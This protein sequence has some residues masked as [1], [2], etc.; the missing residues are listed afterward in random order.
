MACLHSPLDLGYCSPQQEMVLSTCR[1]CH[2]V[3]HLQIT[4]THVC[5]ASW[6]CA[7]LL[8]IQ[9]AAETNVYSESDAVASILSPANSD[10]V[11][12]DLLSY[13]TSTPDPIA[14]FPLGKPP[15]ANR[16]V[17]KKSHDSQTQSSLQAILQC[18]FVCNAST[19]VWSWSKRASL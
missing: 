5:Y 3:S 13:L 1:S 17:A 6:G 9:S 15:T 19:L 10:T 7:M 14:F 12:K 11:D 4:G 2:P 16:A 8:L 18:V